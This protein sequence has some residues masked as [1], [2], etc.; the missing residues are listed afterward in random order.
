M[1]NSS[2]FLGGLLFGGLCGFVAGILYAPK[3][4]REMRKQ[5]AETSDDLYHEAEHQ[6]SNFKDKAEVA[7]G[8]MQVKGQDMLR[9]AN[10]TVV[11]TKEHLKSRFD[12]ISGQ[13]SR[14]LVED[15]E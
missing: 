2:N 13:G 11:G 6:I 3:T 10:D 5:I 12:E 1:S 8:D 7:L 4:G 9:K 15:I 14:A